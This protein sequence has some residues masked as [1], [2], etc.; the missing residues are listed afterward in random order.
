LFFFFLLYFSRDHHSDHLHFHR[1]STMAP[2][3]VSTSTPQ[4]SVTTTASN[5][6]FAAA[7]RE[8]I[9]SMIGKRR[10]TR[11]TNV[12]ARQV[13]TQPRSC[14][15]RNWRAVRLLKL[16]DLLFSVELTSMWR[17]H[18][19]WSRKGQAGSKELIDI[20][21]GRFAST[22]IFL[23]LLFASEVG[24]YYSP[25]KIVTDVR[26]S[27]RTGPFA[28]PLEYATGIVLIVSIILTGAAVLANYTALGVF[29][30]IGQDNA[31]VIL[32][33]DIGLYA[34]TLPSRLTFVSIMTF[35]AWNGKHTK[36]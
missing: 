19:L 7:A 17:R 18:L 25:S 22:Q 6:G 9:S 21:T 4:Q 5:G 28:N 29:K 10:S 23:S 20:V 31:V 1:S 3:Q 14:L 33:S 15:W 34:A 24:T 35:L 16:N 8:S 27:L 11:S 12:R 30:C 13:L 2:E 36:Y 26:D 32:R